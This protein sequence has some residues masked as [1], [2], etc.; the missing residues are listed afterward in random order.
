MLVET[1]HEMPLKNPV[2]LSS[3][4]VLRK[5]F[6]GGL[7]YDK[8]ALRVSELNDKTYSLLQLVDGTRTVD[9]LARLY[10]SQKSVPKDI[11]LNFIEELFRQSILEC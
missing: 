4:V 5:E 7:L 10:S 8:K 2:R 1:K 6:F 11:V 9:E 3:K